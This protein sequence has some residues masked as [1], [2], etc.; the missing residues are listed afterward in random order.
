MAGRLRSSRMNEKVLQ[1]GLERGIVEMGDEMKGVLW[2]IERSRDISQEGLRST[3]L[4]GFESMSRVMEKAVKNI[5]E[6]MIKEGRRRDRGDREV[7]ERLC[8]LEER[9]ADK[10]RERGCE[11]RR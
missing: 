4:K 1:E 11:E 5:G 7:E 6:R 2:K 8:R 9:M 10:G 3:L